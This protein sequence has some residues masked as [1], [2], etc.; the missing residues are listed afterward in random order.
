MASVSTL[1]PTSF[2]QTILTKITDAAISCS[3]A[4]TNALMCVI[5]P[6]QAAAHRPASLPRR[7][8]HSAVRF[9]VAFPSARSF[10]PSHLL[11]RQLRVIQWSSSPVRVSGSRAHIRCGPGTLLHPTV[12]HRARV[13]RQEFEREY[14]R[15]GAGGRW[16][17]ILW[18]RRVSYIAPA[19]PSSFDAPG[20]R[21]ILVLVRPAHKQQGHQGGSIARRGASSW[22]PISSREPGKH[23]WR[24]SLGGGRSIG[25]CGRSETS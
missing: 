18:L 2:F 22:G 20:T 21:Y 13:E 11:S 1:L 5:P 9:A 17:R 8:T 16:R 14:A 10:C 6:A 7:P 25:C 19:A 23:M 24:T 12:C 15:A 3:P 4:Y